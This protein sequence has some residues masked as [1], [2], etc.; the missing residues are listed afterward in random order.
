MYLQTS[1]PADTL[2]AL[3]F[4]TTFPAPRDNTTGYR[5]LPINLSADEIRAMVRDILG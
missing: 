3:P 5:P 4:L 1:K 2:P